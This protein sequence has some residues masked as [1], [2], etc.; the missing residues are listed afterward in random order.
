M[1]ERRTTID[2][3]GKHGMEHLLGIN[4]A[5][6]NPD[7]VNLSTVQPVVD[8][9]MQGHARIYDPDNE[10]YNI[11]T[12]SLGGGAAGVV[13]E[14][15]I[16][17]GN[18]QAAGN[19][20][21][22]YDINHTLRII[23]LWYMVHIEDTQALLQGRSYRIDLQIERGAM[24]QYVPFWT[25]QHGITSLIGNPNSQYYHFPGDWLYEP[26]D[27]L[28][29]NGDIAHFAVHRWGS[30]NHV[31]CPIVPPTWGVKIQ[32][33]VCS[34]FP[35]DVGVW[36]FPVNSFIYIRVL[37]QQVPHGAPIPAYW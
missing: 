17:H 18:H 30:G 31:P 14:W 20:D 2:P 11:Q 3:Q 25:A 36:T 10:R 28:D 33:S 22:V 7:Y 26:A 35:P 37:A 4:S 6:I 19:D 1:Q 13:A 21:L 12:V 27:Y 29:I 8:M 32:A 9:S 23:A 16:S 15:I 34:P 5:Q 24:G